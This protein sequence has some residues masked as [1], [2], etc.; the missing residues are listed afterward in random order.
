[1]AQSD[2]VI[3]AGFTPKLKDKSAL[4]SSL[5]YNSIPISGLLLQ[6]K[7]QRTNSDGYTQLYH[8]QVDEFKNQGTNSDEFKNQGTNSDGYTQLYHPPVDE[9]CVEKVELNDVEIGS[10]VTLERKSSGSILILIGGSVKVEN[11]HQ[12]LV[13]GS[14]HFIPASLTIHLINGTSNVLAFRAFVNT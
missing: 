6:P 3:R 8:P 14:V 9:F 13:Q 11:T 5:T 10:K 12:Q 7:N 1:M 2:N 4:V